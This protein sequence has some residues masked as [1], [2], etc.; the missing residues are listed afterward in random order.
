MYEVTAAGLEAF[1]LIQTEG[2]TSA[3][4]VRNSVTSGVL[5]ATCVGNS[6]ETEAGMESG[7]CA[8]WPIEFEIAAWAVTG[9]VCGARDKGCVVEA[10]RP[11]SSGMERGCCTGVD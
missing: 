3:S 9:A 6:E 5:E 10:D 8:C 2:V 11:P 7:A 1:D 4:A